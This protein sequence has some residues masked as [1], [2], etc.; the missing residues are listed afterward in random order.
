[1]AMHEECCGRIHSKVSDMPTN[2]GGTTT[3]IRFTTT[4]GGGK[5]EVGAYFIEIHKRLASNYE[6]A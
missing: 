3:T 5:L 1:M 4:I 6:K 2:E